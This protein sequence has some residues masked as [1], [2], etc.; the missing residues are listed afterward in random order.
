MEKRNNSQGSAKNLANEKE[1]IEEHIS[2]IYYLHKKIGKGA[3]GVVFK[4]THKFTNRTVAI[5][6]I[7]NAF[8]N[9]TDTK[10]TYREIFFL[11]ELRSHPNIITLLTIHRSASFKDVYLI[12]EYMDIDLHRYIKQGKK[13]EIEHIRFITYQILKGL[14]Y[15]HSGCVIHRDLKPANILLNVRCE[16]KIADFGLA[17]CVKSKER[18]YTDVNLTEYVATRWYRAPEILLGNKKYTRAIDLW[19]VGC[20]VAEMVRGVPLFPG[21]STVNQLELV[22]SAIPEPTVK[23]INEV[24]TGMSKKMLEW[25]PEE[26]LDI[27]KLLTSAPND[28]IDI[29]IKLLLFNPKKRLDVVEGLR[30]P[31]LNKYHDPMNEPILG[32]SLS[33]DVTDQR[34]IFRTMA[35]RNTHAEFGLLKNMRQPYPEIGPGMNMRKISRAPLHPLTRNPPMSSKQQISRTFSLSNA[36]K[37]N[38][39][40]RRFYDIKKLPTQ[41]IKV[42]S[43]ER[44]KT[45]YNY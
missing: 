21:T 44:L 4:A 17:R 27:K 40:E 6:K 12:F 16:A 10:R 25:T 2:R 31:F 5:K 43:Q 15:I 28:L 33:H 1:V 35:N 39:E 38:Q 18:G 3:Y 24:C 37:P 30:H 26:R 36:F 34:N 8:L 41:W 14:K 11:Q 32:R 45:N 22:L 19:S 20:I 42:N 7:F 13:L 23:D 29:T 9:E